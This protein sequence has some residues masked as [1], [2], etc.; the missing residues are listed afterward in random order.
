M[1]NSHFPPEVWHMVIGNTLRGNAIDYTAD[2]IGCSHQTVF[3]MRHKVL[4][5]LRRLPEVNGVCRGDVSG[6]DETFVLDCYKVK[7][8]DGS[9]SR[10]PCK[11]GAKAE[12]RA[13]PMN[14][15]VFV[16]ASSVKGKYLPLRLTGQNPVR[17]CLLVYSK[18]ILQ[19]V[20]SPCVTGCLLKY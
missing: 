9:I 3:D 1:S 5:S 11:H 2:K 12:K 20:H 19:M 10:K 14:I 6:V 8:L 13:F 15:S 16:L 7:K 4:M 17:K 18:V